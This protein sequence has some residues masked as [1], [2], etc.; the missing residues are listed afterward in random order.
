M[1]GKQPRN[2]ISSNHV[3][4]YVTYSKLA[5]IFTIEQVVVGARREIYY[6]RV[7]GFREIVLKIFRI[8]ATENLA[9][10]SVQSKKISTTRAPW[11]RNSS[12][13][14]PA[15]FGPASSSQPAWARRFH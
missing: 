12:G 11:K 9:S 10:G 13:H 15:T 5:S 4:R 2:L 3:Q 14:H 1:A 8:S 6:P 7:Q